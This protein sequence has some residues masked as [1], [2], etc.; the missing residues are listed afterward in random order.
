M[1]HVPKQLSDRPNEC[2]IFPPFNGREKLAAGHRTMCYTGVDRPTDQFG[3]P[4]GRRGGGPERET[5]VSYVLKEYIE[6][7]QKRVAADKRGKINQHVCC[8]H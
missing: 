7:K 2:H 1:L 3:L 4:A 8:R 6:L 5:K